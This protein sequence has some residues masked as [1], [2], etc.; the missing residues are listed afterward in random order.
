MLLCHLWW[1]AT[2]HFDSV[3]V[4]GHS[5][6]LQR[7]IDQIIDLYSHIFTFKLILAYLILVYLYYV[8]HI[9]I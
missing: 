3:A 2:S 6:A 8:L 4:S 1:P 5:S 7:R 9:Y